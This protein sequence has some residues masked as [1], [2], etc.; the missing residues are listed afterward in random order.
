MPNQPDPGESSPP[1]SASGRRLPGGQP[2]PHDA[3]GLLPVS[4]PETV[5][6]ASIDQIK[7][8]AACAVTAET[9]DQVFR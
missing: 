1:P 9:L 6:A 2:T 7:T 3:F 4:V 5:H 8:W